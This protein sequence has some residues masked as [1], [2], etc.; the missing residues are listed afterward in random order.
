MLYS[1][2]AKIVNS[3]LVAVQLTINWQIEL[4]LIFHLF[5]P[6]A[7]RTALFF[8]TLYEDDRYIYSNSLHLTNSDLIGL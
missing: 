8:E 4:F 7:I 1:E 5:C 3:V 2:L 6:S